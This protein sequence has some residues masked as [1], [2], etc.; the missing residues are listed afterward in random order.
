MAFRYVVKKRVFGF[1]ES[2]SE[3]YVAASFSIGEI[4]YD[5]LCDQVTKEGMAPRGV[6]KMVM[7]GLIDALST[8]V[9]LGAT[10]KLGDFGTIRPGLNCKSQSEAKDVTADSIYRQKL[11]LTPGKR[12]K[13]MVKSA[14]ITRISTN[15]EE[16]AKKGGGGGGRG[17]RGG[18]REKTPGG[19]AH[20][21]ENKTYLKVG[22]LR[23]SRVS[24]G[25][26]FI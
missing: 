17:G 1:D 16:I 18:G 22:R 20:P 15:G 19:N 9:S 6:V 23:R 13:D 21:D 25:A 14:G 12:L 24:Y 10:V 26:A 2:K 4:S 8:Y 3:K 11:I 5:R 7:D